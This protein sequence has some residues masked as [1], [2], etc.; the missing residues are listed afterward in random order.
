MAIKKRKRM[1]FEKS[2]G[3]VFTDIGFANPERERL[4]AHLTLQTFRI[5]KDRGLTQA[6][7]VTILGIKQP[8]VSALM[9]NRSGNFSVERPIDFLVALGQDIEITVRPTRKQHGQVSIVLP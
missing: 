5:I 3:N 2:S 8:H 6:E 4:K 9:R 1:T 7:A